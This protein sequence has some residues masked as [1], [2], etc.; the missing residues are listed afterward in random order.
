MC[1]SFLCISV[2]VKFHERKFNLQEQDMP[3]AELLAMYGGYPPEEG[4][5]ETEEQ[6]NGEGEVNQGE[7]ENENSN[8]AVIENEAEGENEADEQEEPEVISSRSS[9]SEEN[10]NNHE[11]VGENYTSSFNV[12]SVQLRR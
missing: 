9:T 1:F 2:I 3:I 11:K 5:A 10:V 4:E 6:A 8:D 7:N 12:C